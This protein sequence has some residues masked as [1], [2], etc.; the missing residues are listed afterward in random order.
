MT[1]FSLNQHLDGNLP[2]TTD[3]ARGVCK[4]YCLLTSNLRGVSTMTVEQ[5]KQI[6]KR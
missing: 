2:P 4:R 5:I 3:L 6:H 1:N